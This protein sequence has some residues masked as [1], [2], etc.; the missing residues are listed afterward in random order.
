MTDADPWWRSYII[1]SLLSLT[2]G[3]AGWSVQQHV[4]IRDHDQSQ[5]LELREITARLHYLEQHA[6]ADE[7]TRERLAG[8]DAKVAL[9]LT[10]VVRIRDQIDRPRGR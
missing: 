6:A 5:Q 3:L 10:E 9:L 1:P 7:M 2:L 8:L 4:S